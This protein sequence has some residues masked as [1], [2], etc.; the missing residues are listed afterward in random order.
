MVA[1]LFQEETKTTLELALFISSGMLKLQ[2]MPGGININSIT[3]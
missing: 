3:A 1:F 2:E